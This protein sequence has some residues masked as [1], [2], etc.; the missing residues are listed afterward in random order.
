MQIEAINP[1]LPVQRQQ[2]TDAA[3]GT[4]A[5]SRF[6]DLLQQA[7]A[8]VNRLQV[9]A[10]EAAVSLA[11]GEVED[12]HQVMIAIEQA[13]LAMELTVQV[14]NKIVDAYQEISRMQI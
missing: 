14:R 2:Q 11:A 10:E 9:A 4:A 7:L 8:K 12:V 13:R 6:C 3:D 5:D 1:F